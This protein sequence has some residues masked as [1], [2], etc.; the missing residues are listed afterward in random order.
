MI[1][2]TPLGK[3]QTMQTCYISEVDINKFDAKTDKEEFNRLKDFKIPGDYENAWRFC[4]DV[5]QA[6]YNS[7]IEEGA[8]VD[9]EKVPILKEKV[10]CKMNIFCK[11]INA[12]FGIYNDTV[13]KEFI[14]LYKDH[15][16]GV[17]QCKIN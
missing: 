2:V 13:W 4:F 1:N 14:R 17:L 9:Y 15:F 12:D 11:T 7:V 3:I 6:V 16:S 5:I 8:I 10:W